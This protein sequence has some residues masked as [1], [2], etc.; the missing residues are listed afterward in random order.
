MDYL[1]PVALSIHCRRHDDRHRTVEAHNF[2]PLAWAVRHAAMGYDSTDGAGLS[3]RGEILVLPGNRPTRGLRQ[4]IGRATGTA[5]GGGRDP[6]P[7][8][9]LT[10]P[11]K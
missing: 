2:T 3:V 1:E 9:H 10:L 11:T 5:K 7:D 8:T 4:S 6:V